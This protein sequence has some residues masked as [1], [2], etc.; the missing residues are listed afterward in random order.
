MQETRPRGRKQ[1]GKE[2]EVMILDLS[3]TCS[4]PGR[5]AHI[6]EAARERVT[7][8]PQ[9]DLTRYETAI[10]YLLLED[11]AILDSLESYLLVNYMSESSRQGNS[12][13]CWGS[14]YQ[15]READSP[16][17]KLMTR[18]KTGNSLL[19][20][21]G[22]K[23]EGKE[24]RYQIGEVMPATKELKGTEV[25]RVTDGLAARKVMSSIDDVWNMA[26][27]LWE[28]K[29]L[30]VI[31]EEYIL[32]EDTGYEAIHMTVL[33]EGVAVDLHLITEEAFRKSLKDG[34]H[35]EKKYDH[36]S[37]AKPSLLAQEQEQTLRREGTDEVR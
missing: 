4:R 27:K 8:N 19:A 6:I 9:A 13:G 16:L 23:S 30:D 33:Y 14:I 18:I 31:D 3:Q 17:K 29:N 35:G 28:D 10:E 20:K 34:Y 7:E 32:K 37:L 21:V 11:R 2:L 12:C 36:S 15:N 26:A 22:K 1:E 24:L 5:L 25:Y